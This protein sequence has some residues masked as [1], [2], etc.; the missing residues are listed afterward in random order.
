MLIPQLL[1]TILVSVVTVVGAKA[2]TVAPPYS[3]YTNPYDNRDLYV[4]QVYKKHLDT[5]HA[6]FMA[7]HDAKNAQR[8]TRLQ[9]EGSTF[10][11]INSFAAVRT[12]SS[13]T[14][15]PANSRL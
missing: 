11:W 13:L 3:M 7:T 4:P 9:K 6:S 14:G 15:T 1:T 10:I 12:L 8:I 5:T 2:P